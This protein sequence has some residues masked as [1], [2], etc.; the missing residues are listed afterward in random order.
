MNI[1]AISTGIYIYIY[2]NAIFLNCSHRRKPPSA[3]SS[4]V[5]KWVSKLHTTTTGVSLPEVEHIGP[6]EPDMGL[7][8]RS[9]TEICKS[10][11]GQGK[12]QVILDSSNGLKIFHTFF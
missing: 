4:N 1:Y 3:G 2:M 6:L 8:Q 12:S 9:G 7:A 10:G 5:S 11:D